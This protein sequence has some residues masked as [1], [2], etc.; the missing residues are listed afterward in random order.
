MATSVNQGSVGDAYID[1]LL[2]GTKWSGSFTFSFPQV[3]GDYQAG[4][5]EADVGSGFAPVTFQQR[6][7]TRA[8]MTGTTFSGTSNVM[9]AT[10]VNSFI[11]V[12]VSEAG[13]L[14]NGLNGNGDIRLG[15]SNDANPTAY[16]YYP[17]N[18]ANGNGGDVWFG[19]ANNYTN[20]IMGNYAYHTHIH[21]LGHAM[22]LKHSHELGGVANVAVP[23]DKDSI[24]WTVMSY[25]SYVGGP[26]SGGYTYGTWDAPQTFMMYDIQA[27]QTMYGAY[28]G[29]NNGATTYSWSST[30][31]QTFINGVSQGTPGG[32]KIFMTVWD[33]GGVDTYDM[34]N[35][36]GGVTINLNP[37][38]SSITSDVQRAQLGGGNQAQGNVYNSLLFNGN[39][40]SIIEN[41]IGGNGNDTITGNQVDN[42]LSG[43]GGDDNLYGGDGN[44]TLNG[45]AGNDTL[46][47]GG[48]NDALNGG[49]DND[50]L[51][52]G[53]GADALNGGLGSD[54]ADYAFSTSVTVNL[55]TG[56]SLGGDAAGDTYNSIE[57][58]SGSGQGD[59]LTGDS[60][61]NVLTGGAGG[62]GLYG[63]GD[64]DTLY[65]GDDNDTLEGGFFT[66]DVYG[67]NGD[68]YFL[69]RN[70][71]FYDNSYG[72]AGTDSL[73]HSLSSYGG[74]TFDF[75][76]G[77]ITGSGI[78]G[79]SAVLS[80]IETYYDG[81]GANTIISG[82]TGGSYY[83]GGGD[84]TM[85][86][87]IGSEFMYGGAGTDLID[88]TRYNGDY[89]VNMTTG[90]TNFG[91]E[92][93]QEFENLNSGTGNDTI[94]GNA[95]FNIINSGAGNDTVIDNEAQDD[96]LNGGTGVDTLVSDLTYVDDATFNMLTGLAAFSGGTFLHFS[97]FENITVGGSADIIGDNGNNFLTAS[98][99]VLSGSNTI[100]G[101]GGVDVITSGAGNDSLYG[102]SGN[103]QLYAGAGDDIV[104]GGLGDDR[105]DGGAGVDTIYYNAAGSALYIDL[106]VATQ[107]ATGGFGTDVITTIENVVGGAF[108]DTLIGDAG[109]NAL[110][111]GGG[112]DSLVLLDGNDV[113][114]GGAGDDYIAG[115]D[116]N[117]AIYGDDNNDVID[118]G[119]GNDLLLG[120]AGDDYIIGGDGSD[121]IYGGDG[122]ANVGDIGDR[123]LGGDGGDDVIYGNLGTDRLSGGAG[124]DF[125]TGGEGFDYMTG[126]AGI[127]TFVY[128]AL[129][130]GSIS[131]Q[132]GDWQGGVDRLQIDASAFGGGL[133]A[134]ALA[135]NRLVMG[136]V[137]NQAFGQFLY[138]TGNG[139]LYWDAD[140]TGA[141]AA[142][143]F[144]RL[145]TSAF[146]LPPASL[147]ATD[148]LLVA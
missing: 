141:G 124:N 31:G 70:G 62:D 106:R 97:N 80:S 25:R 23:S 79:A 104:I 140:G 40:A 78:N 56:V 109:V 69:V 32:N 36:G 2:I 84:D 136:T 7:A 131:E 1:G 39:L 133:A 122:G 65:G 92:L 30:T 37:G 95:S 123:W 71:E 128:N 53:G 45:D 86:A 63:G 132:I 60:N 145:F 16:G 82:G 117:D 148:F 64:L 88:L 3:T 105:I 4:N 13:G 28:Y 67:G 44:D 137:A 34:S 51:K 119:L 93:Y 66:D 94:T 47:G 59:S 38:S 101:G 42:V 21:E 73:D 10:N 52:G 110:Y 107:T 9:L 118:G 129:S 14:G 96:N 18:N 46:K 27:L 11:S 29:S 147:A 111:G 114:Y 68:D 99:L 146:T 126:E 77:T 120:N 22:G 130:E 102:G 113:G 115:R 85:I 33:G 81:T 100:D 74:S 75:K 57:N 87:E 143:A 139:V 125:L 61:D 41:A 138:N 20:P 50:T 91:G 103:D 98:D 112:T 12:S 6:E 26:S 43:N 108:A 35:F 55:G 135:A 134:G 142:V 17:N 76:L 24:E 58:L 83:G 15:Q 5:N 144:T 121:T 89:V 19:T 48:G 49:A 116:G 90:L 72:G 127:D 8:I 54:T